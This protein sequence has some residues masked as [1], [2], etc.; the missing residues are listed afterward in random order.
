MCSLTIIVCQVVS[1]KTRIK[2]MTD[3][4]LL[5][6]FMLDPLLSSY[7]AIIMDEVFLFFLGFF[8]H[9]FHSPPRVHA[10]PPPRFILCHYLGR[11]FFAFFFLVF[12]SFVSILLHELMLDPFLSSYSAIILDEVPE[13][14]TPPLLILCQYLGGGNK[15]L[16]IYLPSKYQSTYPLSYFPSPPH[17]LP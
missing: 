15:Y 7:S 10:C 9:F 1:D 13:P 2:F 8:L 14:C 5:R 12:P 3:G 11:D 16:P 17:T 4:I 6:E